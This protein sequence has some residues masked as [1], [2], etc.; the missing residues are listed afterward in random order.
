MIG[1]TCFIDENTEKTESFYFLIILVFWQ[2]Y[3]FK[4]NVNMLLCNLF[5]KWSYLNPLKLSSFLRHGGLKGKDLCVRCFQVLHGLVQL[6]NILQET[7]PL[8]NGV[9]QNRLLTRNRSDCTLFRDIYKKRCL[10]T[11]VFIW[12]LYSTKLIDR[13]RHSFCKMIRI[14]QRMFKAPKRGILINPYP[15]IMHFWKACS[16]FISFLMFALIS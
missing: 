6:L 16:Y 11:F 1:W 14:L 2:F 13:F 7:S 8:V 10:Y 3:C 5:E 12:L 9:V 4:G 15:S